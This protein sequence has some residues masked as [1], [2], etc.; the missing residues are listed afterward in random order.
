VIR[1]GR[2]T[3]VSLTI[4]LLLFNASGCGPATEATLRPVEHEQYADELPTLSPVTLGA[5]DRLKVVA[6]TSIVGDVVGNV[7]GDRIELQVLMPRGTD[8]HAF[9]PTPRDVAAVAEA[10]IVYVNGLGLEAFLQ[11]LLESA[12]EGVTI[13]PVS[14]GVEL[15]QVEN[16]AESG[17]QYGQFDPHTWFDP[18]NV[19][20]WVRNIADTLSALD[21]RSA[22]AFSAS[23]EAYTEKLWALD[24]WISQ[25]T[26]RVPQDRRELVTDHATLGYFA[27]RYRF[28]Q[29]GAVFPGYSTLA[30]PSAQDVARLEDAIVR[31]NVRAVFVGLTVNPALA[32]RIAHDTG[33]RLVFLYTGSLSEP[34]GPADSYL[35]FMR[36]NVS[37]MVD[38]LL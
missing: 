9:Q 37:A 8:P 27:R 4:L 20:V 28:E 26:A 16:T 10:H 11:P 38:A 1:V 3:F 2:W 30:E 29:V 13:V 36:H 17:D 19:M 25:E 6:T 15:L 23:A 5:G 7:A 22:E 32:Q 35:S 12:G 18:H 34:G 31:F 14:Q 21:P 33:T 24:A